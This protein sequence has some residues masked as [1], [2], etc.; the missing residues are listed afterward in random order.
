MS[1]T[2]P[3]S[4]SVQSRKPG[5][6]KQGRTFFWL[7]LV[8]VFLIALFSA[9]L[10]FWS[11]N[12]LD[13]ENRHRFK[14]AQQDLLLLSDISRLEQ[15]VV[16]IHQ[17]VAE[18]LVNAAKGAM[19]EA[20][21]Y[22]IHSGVVDDLAELGGRLEGL[23]EGLAAVLPD[24]G[25]NRNMVISYQQYQ[26]FII[27][28]TDIA[29]IDP[30]RAEHHIQR[31]QSLFMEMLRQWQ[32]IAMTLSGHATAQHR[33]NME[34]YRDVV[35]QLIV[36]T[37]LFLMVMLVLSVLLAKTLTR[38]LGKVA[39]SL[40]TLAQTSGTPLPLPDMVQMEQ[41][42][43]GEF[44]DLATAT[45][46]FHRT[47]QRRYEVETQLRIHQ[48]DLEGLVSRRTVELQRYI[49]AIDDLG[50]GLCVIDSDHRV[51]SRNQTMLEWFGDCS[52]QP[53]HRVIMEQDAPCSFCKLEKVIEQ[54]KRMHYEVTRGD[55]RIFAVVATPLDNY[56]GTTSS[57][58]LIRDI[59]E[60]K[61]LQ[62]QRLEA[63]RQ[64]EELKKLASLKTMAGAIAHRFNNAMTAVLG[65]LHMMLYTLPEGSDQREMALNGVQAAKG[66][67]QIGS[68]ML[69]YVGQQSSELE[70]H[71]F[72]DIVKGS[73]SLMKSDLPPSVSLN[74][75]AASQPLIC[76]I[77]QQ[78]M[79]E[80]IRN[81]I[82]NAIESLGGKEGE[83]EVSFGRKYF[84][85]GA[86][87]VIFQGKDVHDGQYAFCQIRDSGHGIKPEN[88]SRIFEPFY[89]TRFVGRGL[90][91]TLI[92]GII[93]AHHGAILVESVV[94]RGTTVR[95][96]LPLPSSEQ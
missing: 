73:I 66:A 7:F 56:D 49:T 88:L 45:L 2:S 5:G 90:G 50:I 94:D 89:S 87:P 26:A 35:S 11:L 19:D 52:G 93:Q 14:M 30:H 78:Q 8:P 68:M 10:A 62:E 60:E 28:A 20:A 61:E 33:V 46:A 29:A 34:S 40:R 80:V 22:R 85:A 51:H 79:K 57:M 82:D 67:S 27:M 41:T 18:S 43:V 65:N 91:L 31:A 84:T 15:Q 23:V 4:R 70:Q 32:S 96:L 24:S 42:G 86:F 1:S 59:T 81:I 39:G 44:K 36:W 37:S 13:K 76:L 72:A 48:N 17:I 21:L 54:K 71:S 53:C 6:R 58:E 95:V 25:N 92:V 16:A 9:S 74:F 3:Q 38:W 12:T 69:N 83:I 47:I 64:G 77:D 63:S 75:I 55:G